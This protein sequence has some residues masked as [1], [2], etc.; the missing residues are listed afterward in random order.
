MY[1]AC[2]VARNAVFKFD[3]K[4]AGCTDAPAI[5]NS[6]GRMGMIARNPATP[7]QGEVDSNWI[8][9]PLFRFKPV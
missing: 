3:L 1:F 7:P 8:N 9:R 6:L 2:I 4:G 5:S